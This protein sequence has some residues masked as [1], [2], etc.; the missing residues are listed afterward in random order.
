MVFGYKGLVKCE[1]GKSKSESN[2]LRLSSIPKGRATYLY[3][4]L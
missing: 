4:Y 1:E 3:C 2:Q